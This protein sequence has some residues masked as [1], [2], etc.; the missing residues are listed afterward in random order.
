MNNFE[1]KLY[2]KLSI[3]QQIS[4]ESNRDSTNCNLIRIISIRKLAPIPSTTAFV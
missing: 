3:S 2:S 1:E 4:I